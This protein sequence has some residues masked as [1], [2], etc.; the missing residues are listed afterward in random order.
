MVFAENLGSMTSLLLTLDY[1]L[2]FGPSSGTVERCLIGPTAALAEI[3]ERHGLRLTLFVDAG[4]LCRAA[5]YGEHKAV[6]AQV[7]AVERQLSALA[8][9]GHDLQLHVHPHWED[10]HWT[11]DGWQFDLARYRLHDHDAAS[12]SDIVRRYKERLARLT[13]SD[14]FAF[15]AGGWCLQPFDAISA[16]LAGNGVWLD[17]TVFAGGLSE[18]RQRGFDFT[19]APR[20][21]AW[22]FSADPLVPDEQGPF[23]EIAITPM[24]LGPVSYWLMALLPR[25]SRR[26]SSL[27]DGRGMKWDKKYYRDRLLKRSVS[28]ASIDGIK[29]RWVHPLLRARARDSEAIVNVM[30]HPKA[31]SRSSLAEL[32]R[33]LAAHRYQPKTLSSFAALRGAG[34]TALAG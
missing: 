29:A 4:F 28:P 11:D 34:A 3:A 12:R 5:E 25:L 33:L 27:G 15:R 8:R 21:D 32:D 22:R 6:R 1:E 10:S 13:D 16:A 14:V 7:D 31:V 23:T 19:A 2:F 30:G 18:D 9:K 17:S 26:F 20:A 24:P